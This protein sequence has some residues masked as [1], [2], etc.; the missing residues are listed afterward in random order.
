MLQLQG[1]EVCSSNQVCH[2]AHIWL[3]Q[4]GLIIQMSC[5]RA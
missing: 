2:L 4:L 3:T 1:W 5:F